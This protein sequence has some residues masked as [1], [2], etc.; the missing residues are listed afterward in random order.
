MG[1]NENPENDSEKMGQY[2]EKTDI[3]LKIKVCY[4][5]DYSIPSIEVPAR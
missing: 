4:L 2:Q 1:E 3:V 5:K